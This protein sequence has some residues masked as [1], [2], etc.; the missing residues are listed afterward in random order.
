MAPVAFNPYV[1]D[2]DLALASVMSRVLSQSVLH[3]VRE[4]I[5]T[6]QPDPVAEEFD[7]LADD[8]DE[9]TR[10]KLADCRATGGGSAGPPGRE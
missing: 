7:Q 2:T 4:V 3:A 8:A 6:K 1:S 10:A 5:R 9:Q